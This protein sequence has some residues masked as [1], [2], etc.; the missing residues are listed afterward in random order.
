M[1]SLRFFTSAG[2]L[3][4]TLAFGACA[5]GSPA[6]SAVVKNCTDV[7]IHL[8][9]GVAQGA[10]GTIFYPLVLTTTGPA[11]ALWGTPMVQPVVGGAIHSRLSVGPAARNLSRGEMPAHHILTRAH[12]LSAAFGVSESGNY[13]ASTCRPRNAGGIIVTLAPFVRPRYLTLPI[14]VCTQIASTTT[15]LLSPGTT[16]A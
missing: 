9:V 12:A 3:A 4:S 8:H 15:Q 14:S 16:G 1:T 7:N 11:C 2:L 13:P 5:P 10:A 6:A